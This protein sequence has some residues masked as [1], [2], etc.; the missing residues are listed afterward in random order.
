MN[1]LEQ[2]GFD[3]C[4]DHGIDGFRCYVALGVL[5]HNLQRLG[6]ILT[7][8]EHA[9]IN[10]KTSVGSRKSAQTLDAPRKY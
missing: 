1:A 10:L 3:R 2:H 9:Q 8:K 6:V 4:P 5:A 7:E